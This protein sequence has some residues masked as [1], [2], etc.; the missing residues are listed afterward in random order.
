MRYTT[1]IYVSVRDKDAI[2]TRRAMMSLSSSSSWPL[3]SGM[4]DGFCVPHVGSTEIALG[5][6]IVTIVPD[7]RERSR[8]VLNSAMRDDDESYFRLSASVGKNGGEEFSLY[9]PPWKATL[10]LFFIIPRCSLHSGLKQRALTVHQEQSARLADC[11]AF[12]PYCA[13]LTRKERDESRRVGRE[14]ESVNLLLSPGGMKIFR[15]FCW[16]EVG[17]H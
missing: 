15:T 12:I 2:R 3:R 7:K 14:K 5:Y 9:P 6:P 16:F 10:F 1:C 11:L 4:Q 13:D 8:K 17:T